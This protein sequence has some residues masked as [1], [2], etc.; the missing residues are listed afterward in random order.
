MRRGVRSEDKHN[1]MWCRKKCQSVS[2]SAGV[3]V[4]THCD[5]VTMRRGD[6]LVITIY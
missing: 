1:A 2:V 6:G 3:H 4:H 5:T